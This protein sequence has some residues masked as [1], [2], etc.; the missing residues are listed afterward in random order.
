M[1]QPIYTPHRGVWMKHLD[2]RHEIMWGVS[3]KQREI[4]VKQDMKHG[5]IS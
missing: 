5:E 3:V 4:S 1:F 2:S